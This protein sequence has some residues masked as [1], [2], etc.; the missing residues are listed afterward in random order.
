MPHLPGKNARRLALVAAVAAGFGLAR[1]IEAQTPTIP[2]TPPGS[3]PGPGQVQQMLQNNPDLI[4]RLRAAIDSSGLTP[5]QIRARLRAAGYPETLLDQYLSG[6]DTTHAA[7]PNAN[8]LEAVR[9]LGVV[10]GSQFD[11]LRIMSDSA[12]R[13]ADAARADSLKQAGAPRGPEIFGLDVFRR[14]LTL[15][16][17]NLGGP[18]DPGYRLG[19]GD[20]LVLIIT[21]DVELA[22]TL[23]VTRE[24]FIVIPQVGQLYVANL[25]LAELE[26]L[27]YVRLGKVYSGVKRSPSATTK[28]KVTVAQ[29]RTNQVFVVGEVVRPGSFQIASTGTVLTALYAAGGP[30][31]NGSFRRV[32]VRRG[33]KL[34]DSLDI[35]DYLLHGINTHDIRLET[36]DVVFVAVRRTPVQIAGEVVRP[37]IYEL[38]PNETL[39]DLI[40]MAGGFE[41]TAIRRRVQVDRILPPTQREP[42]RDRIL[43]DLAS[44]QFEDGKGPPFG[45]EPGDAVTVFAV[46]QQ[47]RDVVTVSGAVI[48][49]GPIGM[50]PG[51]KLSDAIRLAGGPRPGVYLPQILVTRVRSD[52]SRIQLRS[53]FRDSTGVVENDLPLQEYDE[54]RVFS[55][56]EFRTDR[57]VGITGAV[58][59]PGRVPYREGMTLRDALL[60]AR[61]ATEDAN[62]KEAEIA[63]LPPVR[64]PGQLAVTVRVPLDSS[65]LFERTPDGRYVGPPGLPSGPSGAAEVTLEPYDNVLILRQ[66]DWNLQRTVAITGQVQY[67]GRYSLLHRG[68]RLTDLLKRAGGLAPG[69]Y[70]GGIQFYRTGGNVGRLGVDLPAILKDSTFRDNLILADGDS[71]AIPEYDPMVYVD[72]AVNSPAALPYKAGEDLGYYVSAAGGFSPRADK[73]RPYVVQANGK[74]EDKHGTPTAG[75][76]VFVP[77]KDYAIEKPP[78]IALWTAA[79]SIFASLATVMVVALTR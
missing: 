30:T 13:A 9:V 21:G 68:E 38:N 22:H 33:G 66:P 46:T 71:I 75:A 35:Y 19:P 65:Y 45:M 1:P 48:V 61:G 40:A 64:T 53:S 8:M 14:A 42:G 10:G 27:L 29:L 73:K 28:F 70:P 12:Q 49:P 25:T 58:H 26:D 18:V 56:L 11:T 54:I 39:K 4:Q 6:A 51:M 34:V 5:D 3:L 60:L 72:G 59:R 43:L 37:A 44:S 15:F 7:P 36:G 57:Y 62:L 32:E 79:A 50:N 17:P 41:P 2:G 76:R 55:Q 52:S 47:R 77:Q 23:E 24:G 74:V 16:Q 69:A 31:P 67:P 63:R 78:N 20:V